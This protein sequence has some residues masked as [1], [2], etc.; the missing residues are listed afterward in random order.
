MRITDYADSYFLEHDL[1]PTSREQIRIVSRQ[2]DAWAEGATIDRINSGLVNKWLI[3]LDAK[4]RAKAT[5]ASKRR[6]LLTLLRAAAEDG[7]TEP[8]ARVRK[9]KQPDRTPRAWSTAE[10]DRLLAVAG[11]FGTAWDLRIRIAWDTALRLGDVLTLR[12]GDI[13]RRGVAVVIQHKTGRRTPK[14][15]KA[16]TLAAI[17]RIERAPDAP[18]CGWTANR[19]Q[20]YLEFNLLVAR[21]GIRRGTF[22]W[23]R[24]GSATNVESKKKGAAKHQLGHQSDDVAYDSYVDPY[25][26]EHDDVPSPTG[27]SIG[28]KGFWPTSAQIVRSFL[29]RQWEKFGWR[30]PPAL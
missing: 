14:R 15:L 10:V 24:R 13:D 9:I 17:D 8:L 4:G 21:A 11:G 23:L 6:V 1:A 2:F 3:D 25:L 22:K 7:L 16:S 12:R 27:L 19:R 18:I 30:L 26:L 28:F 20:F 29:A 5:V